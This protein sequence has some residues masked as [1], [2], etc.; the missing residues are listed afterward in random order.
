MARSISQ[1]NASRN[2][3]HTG[4]SYANSSVAMSTLRDWYNSKFFK[5]A[6]ASYY[7]SGN[8]GIANPVSLNTDLNS[9][10]WISLQLG[11]LSETYTRYQTSADAQFRVAFYSNSDVS[12]KWKMKIN[13]VTYGGSGHASASWLTSN[14]I[15][16]YTREQLSQY[17]KGGYGKDYPVILYFSWNGGSTYSSL[18][19]LKAVLA[20]GNNNCH[21]RTSSAPTGANLQNIGGA[22]RSWGAGHWDHLTYN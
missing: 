4:S 18:S 10:S 16:T 20:Y 2:N 19:N 14:N 7:T 11:G 15:D 1:A 17:T 13:G 5:Q 6:N 22:N 3:P 8:S 9:K 21:W 12:A